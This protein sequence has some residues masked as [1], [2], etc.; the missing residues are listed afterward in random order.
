MGPVAA[1]DGRPATLLLAGDGPDAGMLRQKITD[2][3][4]LDRVHMAGVQP[5]REMFAQGHCVVIPSLSESLPYVVL[6]AAAGQRPVLT[7]DVGGINEIFGPTRDKLL[8]AGNPE[9]LRVAMQAF[10]DDPSEA[11]ADVTVRL[12]FIRERFSLEKM[13]NDI[14]ALYLQALDRR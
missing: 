4:L 5:A 11:V 2:L 1:P 12:D 10:L 14:E 9:P 6:E 8:P 7:T 3:G 13:T